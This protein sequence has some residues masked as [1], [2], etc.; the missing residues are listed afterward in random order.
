M[1]DGGLGSKLNDVASV[2]VFD[3]D[4]IV[5]EGEDEGMI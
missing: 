5:D 2:N 3:V 1:D 4:R